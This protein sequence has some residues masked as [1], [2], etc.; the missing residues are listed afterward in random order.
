MDEE[1]PISRR[2][3]DTNSPSIRHLSRTPCSSYTLYTRSGFCHIRSTAPAPRARKPVPLVLYTGISAG[4]TH[5]PFPTLLRHVHVR[6]HITARRSAS[7]FPD[8]RVGVRPGARGYAHHH[9]NTCLTRTVRSAIVSLYR[10]KKHSAL[11]A[12]THVRTR[13]AD[14]R[15]R[16]CCPT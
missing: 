6:E 4:L 14:V 11:F 13:K 1:T 9:D 16:G 3:S 10:G 12:V 15:P 8:G 5:L 2:G 7:S